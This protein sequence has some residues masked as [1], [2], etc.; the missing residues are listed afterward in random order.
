[1]TRQTNKV[2]K[3]RACNKN[4]LKFE[5]PIPL[6]EDEHL[7]PSN[8][9]CGHGGHDEEAIA[10]RMARTSMSGRSSNM[11]RHSRHSRKR[12]KGMKPVDSSP[13]DNQMNLL[14]PGGPIGHHHHHHHESHEFELAVGMRGNVN[15][16]AIDRIADGVERMIGAWDLENVQRGQEYV[17]IFKS[18]AATTHTK[19]QQHVDKMK[20][21]PVATQLIH[22][23][24]LGENQCTVQRLAPQ[25]T[26]QENSIDKGRHG[27]SAMSPIHNHHRM[28]S[29]HGIRCKVLGEVRNQQVGNHYHEKMNGKPVVKQVFNNKYVHPLHDVYMHCNGN[30]LANNQDHQHVSTGPVVETKE[31]MDPRCPGVTFMQDRFTGATVLEVRR[32]YGGGCVHIQ[33]SENQIHGKLSRGD[34]NDLQTS[35][36]KSMDNTRSQIQLV[37]RGQIGQPTATPPP[38]ARVIPTLVNK[39]TEVPEV[40]SRGEHELVQ[41]SV[42]GHGETTSVN[43]AAVDAGNNLSH[44]A[45]LPKYCVSRTPSG[46]YSQWPTETIEVG[47]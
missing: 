37:V 42:V 6:G 23:D 35:S 40:V 5:M 44:V 20:I 16:S 19:I 29:S 1:M 31:F 27:R 26:H 14:N 13:W 24:K 17:N 7:V 21:L 18:L 3:Q 32:D 34:H 12:S 33:A 11:Q 46:R 30:W 2:N 9:C 39:S 43:K 4:L 38:P 25:P 22:R 8:E 36:D 47:E 41:T 15:L 10:A 45:K 28:Q